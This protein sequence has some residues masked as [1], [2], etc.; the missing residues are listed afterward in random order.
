MDEMM[1]RKDVADYCEQVKKDDRCDHCGGKRG[2]PQKTTMDPCVRCPVCKRAKPVSEWPCKVCG[3]S[4]T[5]GN[6]A[7]LRRNRHD[8]KPKEFVQ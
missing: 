6:H 4:G 1:T 5:E 3:K 7:T 2:D 8:Y